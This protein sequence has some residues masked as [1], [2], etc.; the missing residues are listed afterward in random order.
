VI[1]LTRLN[2]NKFFVNCD[3]IKYVEA[4]PDTTLTLVTGEKLLV[5]ESREAVAEQTLLSRADVFRKAWPGGIFALG[6]KLAADASS[7]VQGKESARHSDEP[8]TVNS[9]RT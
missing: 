8:E 5:V 9:N 7:R 6:A 3:L 4:A 2:G 1:E